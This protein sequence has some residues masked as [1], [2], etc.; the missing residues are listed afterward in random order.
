MKT[1]KI[2]TGVVPNGDTNT[3]PGKGD[4]NLAASTGRASAARFIK[5]RLSLRDQQAQLKVAKFKENILAVEVAVDNAEVVAEVV[6]VAGSF[7]EDLGV[8]LDIDADTVGD[9]EADTVGDVD[10]DTVGDGV[11]FNAGDDGDDNEVGANIDGE[12]GAPSKFVVGY[13]DDTLVLDIGLDKLGTLL[14]LTNSIQFIPSKFLS[15][16]RKVFLLVMRKLTKDISSV[17]LWKKFLFLPAVILGNYCG[18]MKH[19]FELRLEQLLQ[20]WNFKLG[21]LVKR[22]DAFGAEVISEAELI[23]RI[24]KSFVPFTDM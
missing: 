16:T 8:A 23:E 13:S 15:K 10:A 14:G 20:D 19:E 12:N 3:T 9:T 18:D 21:D 2:K 6:D 11:V 5:P 24:N 17:D 7:V 1:R 4:R 22:E